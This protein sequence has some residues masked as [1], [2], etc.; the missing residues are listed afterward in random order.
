MI[1]DFIYEEENTP[2]FYIMGIDGIGK[3][4]SLLFY[5]CLKNTKPILYFNLQ[6]MKNYPL[7]SFQLFKYEIM[8]IFVV[9]KKKQKD[10]F[11]SFTHYIENYKNLNFWDSLEQFLKSN[12]CL[13]CVII[14]DQYNKKFDTN[15]KIEK[16]KQ[17]MDE[18]PSFFKIIIS[19]SINDYDIKLFLLSKFSRYI[20]NEVYSENSN[21]FNKNKD[22]LLNDYEEAIKKID[23][24]KNIKIDSDN[25]FEKIRIFFHQ[26]NFY[27]N[28]DN[29]VKKK[30]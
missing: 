10:D 18:K 6:T 3:S 21:M 28:E 16:I 25:D 13:N 24:K 27:E 1:D 22:Y 9:R 14:I 11:I 2:I 23:F 12:E 29:I 26:K 7:L 17:L 30:V 15:N 19:S 5:S 20:E 4:F 8:K